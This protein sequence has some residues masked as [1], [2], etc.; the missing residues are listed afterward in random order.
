[1]LV[2]DHIVQRFDRAVQWTNIA[3]TAGTNATN[4]AFDVH[5]FSG[6][7]EFAIVKDIPNQF[8]CLRLLVP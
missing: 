6:P 5:L 1:M 4:P 7:V 2:F 8:I 3:V